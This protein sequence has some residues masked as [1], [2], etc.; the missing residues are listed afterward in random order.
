M[1]NFKFNFIRNL[2]ILDAYLVEARRL[3]NSIDLS[4][5]RKHI[6]LLLI[7]EFLLANL[8]KL[9]ILLYKF[10]ISTH[11][12]IQNIETHFSKILIFE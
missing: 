4:I 7:L 10:A 6:S 1:S 11:S 5:C 9:Y 3:Q 12:T 8:H 2:I